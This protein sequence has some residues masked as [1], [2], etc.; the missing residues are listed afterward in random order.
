MQRAVRHHLEDRVILDG[1]KT[2]V[3]MIERYLASMIGKRFSEGSCSIKEIGTGSDSIEADLVLMHR[4]QRRCRGRRCG[5]GIGRR[6]EPFALALLHVLVIL[7]RAAPG[8]HIGRQSTGPLR[9]VVADSVTDLL[10]DRSTAAQ[11][12]R[13]ECE[14]QNNNE[15]AKR[16]G[17]RR[18]AA[19]LAR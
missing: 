4:I 18:S 15:L 11:P 17:H 1:G 7:R 3:F 6:F 2:V 5:I 10:V 13:E 16:R 19:V 12:A 8:R 9:D 14:S